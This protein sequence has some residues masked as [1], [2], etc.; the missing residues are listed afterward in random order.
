MRQAIKIIL[1]AALIL[2]LLVACGKKDEGDIVHELGSKLDKMSGYQ[3]TGQMQLFTSDQPLDY[4]I[5]IWH[6]KDN[7][8]RI[9]LTNQQKDVTQIVLRNDEGVFVLTPHLNKSFRFQSDW[10]NDKGQVYLYQTLVESVLDDEARMFVDD[11]ENNAYVFEVAANYNNSELATQKIWVNKDDYTPKRVEISNA[12][13]DV[14]VLIEF[15]EFIFDPDFQTEDF[16]MKKN[17]ETAVMPSLPV[18]I[19]EHVNE[20]EEAEEPRDHFG[21]IQPSYTPEGVEHQEVL[22]VDW[23]GEKAVSIKYSGEY[24]YSILETFPEER[25]VSAP[26]G[27]VV[28]LGFTQ[29]VLYGETQQTLHWISDGVEFRL[30]S[31]DLPKEEMV[32]VA[33][34]MQ[35][36]SGK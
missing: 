9:A 2:V 19:D 24:N 18:M 5:E 10:P 13:G 35:G 21:V 15:T 31:G 29:A 30:S 36:Q 16:D 20:N 25:T 11:E 26:W 34:S 6:Q 27:E 33:Q 8:Y 1:L 22:D 3:A 12:N 14:L 28:D 23:N 4:S 17:M 32:N 7:Y